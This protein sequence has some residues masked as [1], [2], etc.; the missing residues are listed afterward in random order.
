MQIGTE[1]IFVDQ[2]A[3][4]SIDIIC[5]ARIVYS[6]LKYALHYIL[7][8]SDFT[9]KKLQESLEHHSE[10]NI[11]GMQALIHMQKYK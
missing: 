10:P 9:F 5:T 6:L 2:V 8:V 1:D 7:L 4:S 3:K 11:A